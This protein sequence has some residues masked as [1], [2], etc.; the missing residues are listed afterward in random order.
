V[1]R[2]LL[3]VSVLLPA[4]L[5]AADG[6]RL[7]KKIPIPG[8]YGWDYLTSDSETRRLYVSHDREVVVLDLDSGA[9]IGK[10]PGEEVHGIAIARDLGRGFISCS[11]PG[12]VIIFDLKTLAVLDKVTVGGDP[13]AILFDQ[14][15]ARVFTA[16][17]GARRITAIDGRTGKI[18]ATSEN[19]GGRTEHAALDDAGHLFLN[20][21]DRHTLLKLD[22][23]SLNVLA[24]WPLAPC[25]QPSSM[26]IDR[27][28][29]RVFI[30]CRSGVMTVVDGNTGRIVITQPIG[31]GVDATEFDAARGLVYFASGDGTL[32]IFHQDTP[33]KYTLTE[34][35]KTQT[36]ARTLAVDHKTGKVFLSVA[37]FGPRPEPTAANPRPRAPMLPGT[38]SVLVM[39]EGRR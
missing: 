13:N 21:Q 20:M 12:S 25:E 39:E 6:Y 29:E 16:D 17:R 24:T 35:V 23:K 26:D 3:L 1:I 14:K 27:A 15:T 36:G 8:D 31:K 37:E 7:L 4:W 22:S 34:S 2:W 11:D 19:L 30:G 32:A 5:G 9:I 33:D 28:H 18:V 10:I 38:F